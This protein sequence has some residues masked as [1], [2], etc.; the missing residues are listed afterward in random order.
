MSKIQKKSQK[1]E[2]YF[3]PLTG[4]EAEFFE[5]KLY[6]SLLSRD[7]LKINWTMILTA[8]FYGC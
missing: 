5:Y 7:T 6:M 3:I 2:I 1:I 8:V 4:F